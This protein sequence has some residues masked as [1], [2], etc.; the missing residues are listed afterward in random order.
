MAT[1]I[2]I[3]ELNPYAEATGVFTGDM[4]ALSLD[5]TTAGT[6]HVAQATQ[7]ATV[8]QVIESYNTAVA[9]ASQP[10]PGTA[11]GAANQ[12]GVI[13]DND[14]DS[15]TYGQIIDGG[16]TLTAS[17]FANY[18]TVGGGLEYTPTPV[19]NG[20][21]T[22][23]I[24]YGLSLATS[25][26]SVNFTAV[27]SGGATDVEYKITENGWI[28]G[29]FPSCRSA[30]HW[31]N[32]NI[33]NAKNI[34]FLIAGDIKETIPQDMDMRSKTI[35][36]VYFMDYGGYALYWDRAYSKADNNNS[37]WVDGY[38]NSYN[39]NDVVQYT[40]KNDGTMGDFNVYRC[41]S[42][43]P[44]NGDPV[45]NASWDRLTPSMTTGLVTEDPNGFLPNNP[46]FSTRASWTVLPPAY[47]TAGAGYSWF[48]TNGDTYFINL[49]MI[50]PY[51]NMS[52]VLAGA[53]LG[54]I[55][56]KE[57]DA[58]ALNIG[59]GVE[60][61]IGG[62]HLNQ[63]FEMINGAPFKVWGNDI[64]G[65]ASVPDPWNVT[66]AAG[67]YCPIPAL[68]LSL[69]GMNVGGWIY[70]SGIGSIV[71]ATQ[72]SEASM[73]REYWS[74]TSTHTMNN[75]MENSRIQFGSGLNQLTACVDAYSASEC[76]GNTSMAMSPGTTFKAGGIRLGLGIT[77]YNALGAPGLGRDASNIAYPNIA[78][79]A[80]RQ[81]ISNNVELNT[82][83]G[84]RGGNINSTHY[85]D[86]QTTWVGNI[87]NN[88]S[89]GD[90]F[91]SSA[92]AGPGASLVQG[93]AVTSAIGL[94][95]YIRYPDSLPSD[96]NPGKTTLPY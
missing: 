20:D 21:G 10:A 58:G 40:G 88:I 51:C 57:G 69:S 8:Q 71:Q 79:I 92:T 43:N 50:F 19:D 26:S 76:Q 95:Q 64:Y 70:G 52:S 53:S 86:T 15:P 60:M 83:S 85:V 87:N 72:G 47:A 35:E 74:E 63:V 73:G 37:W 33:S 17:T 11:P 24:T 94:G 55:F 6:P 61:H 32:E 14:P 12:G 18:I 13:M 4:F 39:P 75:T 5:T 84:Y 31:V 41:N 59:P 2:K 82:R 27:I 38:A 45:S 54:K 1:Y 78:P 29:R 44:G 68:Y 46:L 96:F 81:F 7:R 34:H 42:D 56:R 49:K 80:A 22:S 36:N 62:S 89:S 65:N 23:T 77:G 67:E 48:K 28:S 93:A 66:G 25:A 16:D 30:V 3:R 90:A 91:S 9:R